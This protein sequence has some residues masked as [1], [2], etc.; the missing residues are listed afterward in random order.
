[1]QGRLQRPGKRPRIAVKSA[2]VDHRHKVVLVAA[3]FVLAAL[4]LA[5]RS[6][7]A[8]GSPVVATSAGK[9][10]PLEVRVWTAD[11]HELNFL[12]QDVVKVIQ[13]DPHSAVGH[14]LLAHLMVRFFSKDPS[15]LYILKQAS[16]LAQ[17]AIDL[18]PSA[19]YGYVAMADIL[20]LM[21]SADRGLKLLDDAERTGMAPNWRFAFTRA[22]LLGGDDAG[23]VKTLKL[24]EQALAFKDVEPRVVVPYVVALLQSEASGE[25]LVAKLEDWNK[26]FPSPL[27]ELTEAITDAD[28]GKFQKAHALYGKIIKDDP[29]NKEAKVNDAIVLYR[30]LKEGQRAATLLEEVLAEHPADLS[31]AVRSMVSAH[32][33]AAYLQRKM[34]DKANASFVAAISGEPENL[35]VLDFVTRSYRDAKAQDRLASLLSGLNDQ[36]P[37][38]GMLHAL[39]GETLSEHLGRQD[40]ALRAFSDAITLDP[41]RSDFYN[42]M[43]LAYY[44]KKSYP[45]ALK[46]FV[47]A[48]EIDPNDATA[49]YNAA[50]VLSLMGRGDEAI[51]TLAEAIT[52]DPRLMQTARG[53]SDFAGLKASMKFQDLVQQTPGHP[54]EGTAH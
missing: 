39:L 23:S 16:D 29:S 36:V 52:L 11:E 25:Q 46:L 12:E 53:D 20:D 38:S 22:R 33:G 5:L 8:A 54:T 41:E 4:A 27:F 7:L 10:A 1:M 30:D 34:Y 15:D 28:L 3:F 47:A 19:P 24:L 42:G 32:L 37:G 50:C 13:L 9:D 17:Q 21:G 49:R 43:G 51:N 45:D 26:R 31:P 44:R 35:G 48:T 2:A 14:G 18:A 6:S 40:E